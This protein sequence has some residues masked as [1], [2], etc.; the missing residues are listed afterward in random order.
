MV[1][2]IS[3]A[4]DPRDERGHPPGTEPL[5]SESYYA[6]FVSEDGARAGYLRLGLYPNLGVSWWTAMIVTP[7]Q[8]LV[9][10]TDY[11]LSV[12]AD[13]ALRLRERGLELEWDTTRPLE[14]L[15]VR[16]R[17]IGEVHS[18]PEAVYEGRHGQPLD[19]SIDLTWRTDGSPYHYVVTT[20]YEVPCMVAGR[21]HI[22]DQEIDVAGPGQRDHSWGVRDWWS[23]GWCWASVRL[24]DGTRIH[25]T[26]VH[27]PHR[28]PLGYVQSQGRVEPVST[29]VVSEEP[30][31]HGLPRSAHIQLEPGGI[32]LTVH[33]LAFGPLLLEAPDG[34]VSRFPRAVARYEAA[35][36][37]SGLGWIE[38]NQPPG[39]D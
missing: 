32:D 2:P 25:T 9:A 34:R 26:D 39:S 5:W 28:P 37:R 18:R 31:E 38:W 36:G 17:G 15:T 7:G 10:W 27:F 3:H 4:V 12:P 8:S 16:A 23:L 14:E 20:R 22:G 13:G 29:L 11:Q 30:G 19:L 33:P 6:D 21:L 35:D 1:Q 24:D